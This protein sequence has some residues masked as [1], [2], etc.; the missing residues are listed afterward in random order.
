MKRSSHFS[1]SSWE[2]I[3]GYARA[4]RVGPFIEVA[5]TTA[6]DGQNIYG[7]NDAY[8][9]T[10]FILKRIISAVEALGGSKSDIVRTRMYVTNIEDW[11]EIGRAH[12]EYFSEVCPASTM[13]E[14]S[15]LIDPKLLVEI[16]ATAILSDND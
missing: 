16:E 6:S 9:Q 4:Q 14:V 15:R 12:G 11:P 13:V 3:V 8:T 10:V 1:G 7:E 5:G 2:K